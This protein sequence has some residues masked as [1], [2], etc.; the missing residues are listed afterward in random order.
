MLTRWRSCLPQSHPHG[1]PLAAPQPRTSR[2]V[3]GRSH[4]H[5]A[6]PRP[7]H[8][9]RLP[10]WPAPPQC[11][12]TQ[13]HRSAWG[14][15]AG[16]QA[17]LPARVE[18]P[19]L[20]CE[21]SASRQASAARTDTDDEIEIHRWGSAD[22]RGAAACCAAGVGAAP[23]G[24][25]SGSVVPR[26][27]TP[28]ARAVRL[29]HAAGVPS[30]GCAMAR[31]RRSDPGRSCGLKHAGVQAQARRLD[32]AA[33]PSGQQQ[34]LPDSINGCVGPSAPRTRSQRAQTCHPGG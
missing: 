18:R 23:G 10:I 1:L 11:G 29:A 24:M 28:A 6:A 19:E 27:G 21:A 25:S 15:L 3:S 16:A 8:Q 14:G 20:R 26:G 33:R 17:L 34:A 4:S 32:A 9:R 2:A 22:A 30:D 31:A 13:V 7:S 5:K 12:Y